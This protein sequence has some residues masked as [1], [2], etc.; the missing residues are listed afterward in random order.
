MNFFKLWAGFFIAETIIDIA[1]EY[2]SGTGIGYGRGG[3]SQPNQNGGGGKPQKNEYA[4]I[5]DQL[6]AYHRSHGSVNPDGSWNHDAH[7][8]FMGRGPKNPLP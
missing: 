6:D 4:Q 2:N 1:E 8:V 7:E 5:F 3:S